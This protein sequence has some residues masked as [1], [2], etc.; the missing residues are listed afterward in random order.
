MS[1]NLAVNIPELNATVPYYGRQPATDD[2]KKIKA[3]LQ[4]HYAEKDE[5]VNAGI[6]EYEKALKAAG[7]NY[8]L[9]MYKG[10]QHAFHNDAS[11]DRY[12]K[13][14]AELAWQRTLEFFEKHLGKPA[15]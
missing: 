8:E 13:K 6:A 2:V 7:T 9:H 15:T 1:N 3:P 5:R 12:D 11:P 4:L 14:S 10:A